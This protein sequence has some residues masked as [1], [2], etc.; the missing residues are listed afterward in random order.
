MK[1][2][3]NVLRQN[4]SPLSAEEKEFLFKNATFVRKAGAAGIYLFEGDYE[5]FAGDELRHFDCVDQIEV[6]SLGGLSDQQLVAL[7]KDVR[8]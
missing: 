2:L 6:P 4:S 5:L 7:I 8:L 3:V 1:F